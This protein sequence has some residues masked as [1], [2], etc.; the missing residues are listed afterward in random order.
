MIIMHE[1]GTLYSA[2]KLKQN[3]INPLINRYEKQRFQSIMLLG[4]G[5]IFIPA[6]PVTKISHLTAWQIAITCTK[7]EKLTVRSHE[8]RCW[9]KP[10]LAN[11]IKDLGVQTCMERTLT[12]MNC[13]FFF[14]KIPK[15]LYWD[16]QSDPRERVHTQPPSSS[17][18]ILQ[19]ALS[20]KQAAPLKWTWCFF[21]ALISLVL[22]NLHIYLNPP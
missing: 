5:F 13:I 7:C 22:N 2:L 12:N 3:Y 17:K 6:F 19:V 18:C 16:K 15:T 8:S 9:V 11:F 20:Q 10:V 1:H 21:V 4:L 14:L